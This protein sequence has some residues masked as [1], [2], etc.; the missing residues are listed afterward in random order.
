[1]FGLGNT[2]ERMRRL[3]SDAV[4]E[5][6]SRRQRKRLDAHLRQCQACREEAEFYANLKK[7]A[8]TLDTVSPPTY[9]WERISLQIDEHPWGEGD[10]SARTN[11]LFALPR[12]WPRSVDIAGAV[13]TVALIAL[14]CLI[15]DMS[16]DTGAPPSSRSV[17]AEEYKPDSAYLSLYMIAQGDRFP[18]QVRDYYL[19]Q[20]DGLDTKI[21][22][23]KSTLKRFPNN[24]QVRAQLAKAYGQKI[25]L[26][27]QMGVTSGDDRVILN[28]L[29]SR[30][31]FDRGGFYE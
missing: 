2:C 19:N 8:S 15:P 26:Y 13:V 14:L 28:R 10:R 3:I 27:R 17:R 21:D 16:S 6:L 12:I 23:I 22:M 7:A 24:R 4:D 25:R 9:L 20:L 5:P 11:R 18:S 31:D 29:Y 1:M 30:F